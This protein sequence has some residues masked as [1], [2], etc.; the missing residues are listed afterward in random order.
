MFAALSDKDTSDTTDRS[1]DKPKTAGPCVANV[2]SVVTQGKHTGTLRRS[3]ELLAL[4]RADGA[5][6]HCVASVKAMA[7]E[8]PPAPRPAEPR[9]ADISATLATKGD[10][11]ERAAVVEYDAGAPRAWAERFARLDPD[12]PPNDVPPRRWARFIDDIGQFV[13]SGFAVRAASLGWGPYDLFGCDRDRPF[14]R[15][16]QAGLLW[17]LNGARLIAITSETAV[18]DAGGVRQ[19]YRRAPTEAG[20][21]LAWELSH[22]R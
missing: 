22:A 7:A 15:I 6:V 2:K 20:R 17:L 14:S 9:P 5:C 1:S 13:D 19:V 4:E 10:R 18:I 3:A 21:V 16:D 8:A 12:R 11:R